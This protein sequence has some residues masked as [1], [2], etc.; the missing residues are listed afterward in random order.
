[1][2]IGPGFVDISVACFEKYLLY[3]VVLYVLL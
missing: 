2:I 1:M 3:D